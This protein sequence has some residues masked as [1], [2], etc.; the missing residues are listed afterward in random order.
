MGQKGT[1]K[2][3]NWTKEAIISKFTDKVHER[4]KT[5]AELN[6]IIEEL[7]KKISLLNTDDDT[8]KEI[9]KYYAQGYQ[10][11]VILDKMRY[12]AY[13]ISIEDIRETCMSIDK[14]E[15]TYQK[16]Y[17]KQVQDYE[18][19]IK[20][21]PKS[22]EKS[23]LETYKMLMNDASVELSN[24]DDPIIKSKLRKEIADL[25]KLKAEIL[26]NQIGNEQDNQ[27]SSEVRKIQQDI[28]KK[29]ENRIMKFN[30]DSYKKVK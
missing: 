2:A 7:K 14:L 3:T 17:K 6:R 18:D 8:T 25:T 19:S 10:Y 1:I 15:P 11:S 4:D 28:N 20:I 12:G 26:K 24:T 13:D 22:I 23:S 21:N 5:I 16:Y 29:K 9:L 30:A 27:T